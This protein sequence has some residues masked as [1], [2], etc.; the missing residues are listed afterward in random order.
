MTGSWKKTAAA[1]TAAVL[2]AAALAA[3]ATAGDLTMKPKHGVS[4]DVGAK[5]AVAYYLARGGICNLT[6]LMAADGDVAEV[7]GAAT[8]ITVPVIPAKA[9]RFDTVEGK[10]MEFRCAPS[11]ASMSVK[12][13]DQVAYAKPETKF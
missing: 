7:R 6:V 8:R 13:L 4:Y 9:A 2:T 10:T 11:A 3:P 5:R 1:A 12:I